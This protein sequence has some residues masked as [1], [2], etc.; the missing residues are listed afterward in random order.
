MDIKNNLHKIKELIFIS[1]LILFPLNQQLH[2]RPFPDVSGFIIDYLIL[3]ISIPEILL[4]LFVI[5]NFWEIISNLKKSLNTRIFVG[6]YIF[7]SIMSVYQSNYKIL[8][9]YE[10]CV[11]LI[12]I[13]TFPTFYKPSKIYLFANSIKFWIISLSILGVLQFYYQSSVLNNYYVFGEFPYNEDFYH[14]KQKGFLFSNLIPPYAIFSHSNIFGGFLLVSI[15]SLGILKKDS[16]YFH[17]LSFGMFLII[18]SVTV[19][20]AY[21]FWLLLLKIKSNFNSFLLV[22]LI[23]GIYFLQLFYSYNYSN[24]QDNYS[25]Y[26]RLYMFDLTSNYFASDPI[27]ALFGVGYFNYFSEVKDDLYKYEI[28]R[29]FQPT[30]NLFNFIIWQYGVVF[31][32][33]CLGLLLKILLRLNSV[34]KNLIFIILFVSMFDHYFITNHQLK[35]FLFLILPYSLNYK[36]SI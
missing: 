2:L 33:I 29:F 9:I 17:I 30:H 22:G 20:I 16:L 19:L 32:I 31:L 11:I 7:F 21:L 6:I 12:L 36:N 5:F 4:I 26:R 15:I 25:I 23:I 24:Y 28:V 14:I 13:L 18:G 8:G 3:K 34:S 27:K 35:L 10:S 1:I